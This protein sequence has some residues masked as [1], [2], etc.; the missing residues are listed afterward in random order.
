MKPREN[1]SPTKIFQI[2]M[3]ARTMHQIL[4]PLANNRPVHLTVAQQARGCFRREKNRNEEQK[5]KGALYVYYIFKF[6]S[7]RNL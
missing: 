2:L 5:Q 6:E 1:D 3:H 7:K 4:I